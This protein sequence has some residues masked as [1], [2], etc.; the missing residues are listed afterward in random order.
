MDLQQRG[1]EFTQLFGHYK[2]LRPPLLEKMPAMQISRISS[3]NGES[4]G[5]SFDD[6]SPD[7]IENGVEG[8][9]GGGHSLIESNMNTLG[10][11]TVC[12]VMHPIEL[13]FID[14]PPH[15]LQNILLDLLGSTDLSAGG[16][17][18]LVAATDLSNAVHKKNSR[19]ANDVVAPVSN[20]Q[21]LLDLLD[22]D[23]SAPSS[24]TTG[25]PAGG[26]G[27]GGIVALVGDNNQ[28]SAANMNNMLGGLDLGGF[29]SG[30]DSSASIPTNGN[31][32]ASMLGGLGA[33]P[34]ASPSLAASAP[35][36]NLIDGHAGSLLAD[37]N[38]TAASNNVV[39]VGVPISIPKSF[40]NRYFC[41]LHR[42]PG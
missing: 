19:N 4:G 41:S 12:C 2:H 37:L 34:A 22:L 31:D 38:P 20:N 24:T 15:L 28:S 1:V 39:V 9:G 35:V 14:T 3:Q 5:G 18:D 21:D 17:G 33:P 30:L 8:G 32:L 25:A 11:N 36:G 23:L 29:G 7:V 6:N 27:G 10:D 16:A 40:V 13:I 26:G 42:V